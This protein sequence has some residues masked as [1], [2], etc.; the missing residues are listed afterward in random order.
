M[1]RNNTVTKHPLLQTL[2][3]FCFLTTDNR[4][5][6]LFDRKI[7]GVGNYSRLTTKW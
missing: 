3:A 4:H 7:S 1:T 5:V 2:T 6:K